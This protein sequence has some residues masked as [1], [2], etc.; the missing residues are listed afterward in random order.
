MSKN[1]PVPWEPVDISAL[2]AVL[3]IN[4]EIAILN[5]LPDD[6]REEAMQR[7]RKQDTNF[8]LLLTQKEVWKAHL[9][10]KNP[11]YF[12]R[13][14]SSVEPKLIRFKDL[15]VLPKEANVRHWP[16]HWKTEADFVKAKVEY[17][18]A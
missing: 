2:M 16:S 3:K 18:A 10:L 15:V 4:K 13:E 11:Y 7:L 17:L 9:E 6:I 12:V 5:E 14:A 1:A 8:E